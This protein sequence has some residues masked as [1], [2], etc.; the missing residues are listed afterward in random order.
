[1]RPM[2]STVISKLQD[3]SRSQAVKH[4]VKVIMSQK[5]CKIGKLLLQTTNR[6]YM[7]YWS[8]PFPL[9]L[10]SFIADTQGHSPIANLFKCDF[11]V[12]L[13]N[14]WHSMSHSPSVITDPLVI[15]QVRL[16]RFIETWDLFYLFIVFQDA[17]WIY[18]SIL[19]KCQSIFMVLCS[20]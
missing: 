15:H 13:C 7:V 2:I 4:T 18:C 16:V 12:Q 19:K 9:T 20:I 10:R 3:L 17:L 1:M 6:N 11:F 8:V 5:L 14:S